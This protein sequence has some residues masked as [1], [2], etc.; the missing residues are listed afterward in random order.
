VAGIW[1]AQA[2][3]TGT[4]ALRWTAQAGDWTAVAMNPD[5]SAGLAVRADAGVSAPGL[6]Q[7][8]VEVIIGGIL[9]GLLSAALIWVPAR[10]A[11]GA[12]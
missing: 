8:A 11:T 9:A 3:G 6:F 12:E 1:V 7:L 10:L 2:E 4:Q 5:G